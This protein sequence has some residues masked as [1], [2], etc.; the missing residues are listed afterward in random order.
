VT[1]GTGVKGVLLD[2]EGTTTPIGF[3]HEV[4]FPYA[5]RHL[6]D[7]QARRRA[8]PEV[9]VALSQ[10]G[11]EH[12][13]A[14]ARGEAVPA[15]GDGLPYL[16]FLMAQDRK[17]AGLKLLQGLVWREGYESGRLRGQ[18]FADVAPAFAA[19]RRAGVRLRIFSSGSVLAQRLLFA[20]TPEGDLTVFLDGF[21]DLATGRK[22][23]PGAY[24]TIT[25]AFGLAPEQVLFVSDSPAELDAAAAAGLATRL[26]ERPG[27]APVAA[28]DHARIRSF[29]EI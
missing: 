19:W 4:L 6:E 28:T 18:V 5:A 12:G 16:R 23:D 3:V 2:V 21:H 9:A 27:N 20:T 13:E 7:F 29:A 14:V 8:D 25:G 26:A 22:Q 1:P 17:S 11:A 15:F 10:L 24:R